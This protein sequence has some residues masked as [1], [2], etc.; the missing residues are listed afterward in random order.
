MTVVV[1]V[2][3][4]RYYLR[5]SI[6]PNKSHRC[7][8]GL[9]R[10]LCDSIASSL[11]LLS[12]QPFKRT[13]LT[14]LY[15]YCY[16]RCCF[17]ISNANSVVRGVESDFRLLFLNNCFCLNSTMKLLSCSLGLVERGVQSVVLKV[18]WGAPN[19]FSVGAQSLKSCVFVACLVSMNFDG[20]A[21]R[22]SS[23][24]QFLLGRYAPDGN[25]YQN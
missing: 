23:P 17:W 11:V 8:S 25:H 6:G 16:Y 21:T 3:L 10:Y 4:S 2:A 15:L 14:Y 5:D 20:S 13:Y 22:G 18:S 7:S 12:N 1:V 19:P 9:N 24:S